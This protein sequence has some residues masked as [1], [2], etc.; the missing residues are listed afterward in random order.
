MAPINSSLG[1]VIEVK[2]ATL[3]SRKWYNCAN[4]KHSLK[5]QPT[6]YQSVFTLAFAVRHQQRSLLVWTSLAVDFSSNREL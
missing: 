6:R 1:T 4:E 5:N 2:G 3:L